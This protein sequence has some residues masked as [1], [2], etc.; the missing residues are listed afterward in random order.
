[1][2]CLPSGSGSQV[3][4]GKSG[5]GADIRSAMRGCAA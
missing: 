4:Y 5:S 1:M 2:V 3:E